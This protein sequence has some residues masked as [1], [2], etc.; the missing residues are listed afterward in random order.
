MSLVQQV[1]TTYIQLRALDEQLEIA[2]STVKVRQ[3]S[4]KLTRTLAGGG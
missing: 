3:D 1:A 4:V 2:Q